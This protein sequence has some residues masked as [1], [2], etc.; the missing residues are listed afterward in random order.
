[1]SD[2]STPGWLKG[3]I[4][5]FSLTSAVTFGL[6]LYSH[7]EDAGLRERYRNLLVERSSLQ[8]YVP[9]LKAEVEG[10]PSP[11]DAQILARRQ[12]LKEITEAEQ[13]TMGDVS[14][15]VGE[16]QVHQQGAAKLMGDEAKKYTQLLDD[17]KAR[18]GEL[19][20]EEDHALGLER[21]LDDRR[22]KLREQLEVASRELETLKRDSRN[23]NTSQDTRIDELD[24]RIRELTQQR[25]LNNRELR[26]DGRILASRATDGFVVIDRGQ[27]DNLRKGTRFTVFNRRGGKP[28]IKGSVEVVEVEARMAVCRVL[29]EK[30]ANDPLL[31]GD[32]IHNPVYNPDDI[33]TFVIK[34]DF[35]NFSAEEL[36]RFITESGGKVA[37]DLTTAS[38][39]LV[40]GDR[41]QAALDQAAKLGVSILSEDQLLE[42]VR[43]NGSGAVGK[44][45]VVVLAGHF[46]QVSAGAVG[47]LIERSGGR[48]QGSIEPGVDLLIAGEGA[49]DEIAK[50]RALGIKVVDHASFTYLNE[51]N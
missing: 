37:K 40:A 1:M 19:K 47:S 11:L 24:S 20:N 36:A 25:E 7:S 51:K 13:Q 42:L 4:I 8:V 16:A 14:R 50:A 22:V 44:G 26:A 33:K 34:G 31:P 38:D 46:T 39:Y 30:N 49:A 32:M 45:V 35:T 2:S 5:V 48:V 3:L 12:K 27:D 41:A 17:A 6:F 18:R 23:S 28:T 10:S 9:K 15:I 29:E 43:R 21:D